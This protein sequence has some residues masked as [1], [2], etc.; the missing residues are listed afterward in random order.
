MTI[1][2]LSI[3]ISTTGKSIIIAMNSVILLILPLLILCYL[4]HNSVHL[5]L[6]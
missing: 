6:T 4:I 3:E 5:I 1:T 2:N